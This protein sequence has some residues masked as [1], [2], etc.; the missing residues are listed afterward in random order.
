[1]SGTQVSPDSQR[2]VD[3][4]IVRLRYLSDNPQIAALPAEAASTTTSMVF[5]L[6]G[7][8]WEVSPI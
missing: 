5:L 4:R 8:F 2:D 3:D 1:M 7:P 6:F